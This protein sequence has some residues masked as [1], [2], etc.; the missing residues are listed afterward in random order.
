[1]EKIIVNLEE[2]Q[3]IDKYLSETLKE[4]RSKIEKMLDKECITC[5]GN[6]AKSSL[7]IKNGDVIEF[8]KEYRE[9]IDLLPENIPID[10]VFETENIIII[11]KPSG[12]VVHPGSG[13]YE[14]TLANA[15]LYHVKNLSDINE[16]RPGIVHRIDK[17][18]S[19]LLVVAKNNKAHQI[20][21]E[22][23]K[24]HNVKRKYIA[25]V[26]GVLKHNHITV[27]A[28]IG[29]DEKNRKKMAVT[30]KNSKSAIT[31]INVLK[32]FQDY[33]LVECILETGRTHQ[34]RVHLSYIG[35]PI[36]NDPVYGKEEILGFGQFLHSSEIDLTEP[37]TKEQLHFK[38][39]LPKTFQ[40]F[41]K[42]LEKQHD[43]KIDHGTKSET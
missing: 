6:I 30:E 38:V 13:V 5:N 37:I 19:G 3:R 9:E 31:H 25:L 42:K 18:T 15:L 2:K 43:E 24:I 8:V 29:R 7:K 28:P 10:I 39:D 14:H 23:F 22:E 36:F 35:Y 20:L 17:D 32:R 33:T 21:G 16:N 40:D 26:K 11:N 34:I 4:S 1:M 27:D 41:L 12:M